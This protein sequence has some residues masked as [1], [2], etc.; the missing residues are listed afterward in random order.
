MATKKDIKDLLKKLNLKETDMDTY[1][2]EL[3]ELNWKVKSLNNSG[4]TWRDLNISLIEQLPTQK[5]KDIENAER[6]KREEEEKIEAELKAKQEKEYHEEHYEEII[7][8]KIDSGEELNESELSSLV[9]EFEEI[10]REYGDNRRWSRSV[11]SIVK[12][13]NRYF[14]IEWENGLTE[15]QP[16]EFYD[17]PY[18][19]EKKTYEKTIM[20]TE[21]VSKNK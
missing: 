20:V 9:W 13:N 10:E 17:Q 4:K 6:E 19:V 3:I 21:W 12:I 5:Q 18:E 16:N 7:L 1:W 14:C 8:N 11:T 15:N 2:N